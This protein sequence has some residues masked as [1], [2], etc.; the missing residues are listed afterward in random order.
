MGLQIGLELSAERVYQM[1]RAAARGVW[2][3]HLGQHLVP[4]KLRGGVRC[5]RRGV[6]VSD[7]VV[8]GGLLEALPDCAAKECS[9]TSDADVGAGR[10]V[11]VFI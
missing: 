5:F 6:T 3:V 8:A 4:D 9:A 7:N 11:G 10:V 1:V 2:T